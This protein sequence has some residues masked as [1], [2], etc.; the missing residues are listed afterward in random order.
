[1]STA[2]ELKNLND[3]DL[4]SFYHVQSTSGES[5]LVIAIDPKHALQE[6]LK[7]YPNMNV[8]ESVTAYNQSIPEIQ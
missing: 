1:M 5:V 3:K 7:I 6:A 8:D 4:E 2:K